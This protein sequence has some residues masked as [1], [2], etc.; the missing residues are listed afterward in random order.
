[1]VR[2]VILRAL[3]NSER[4]T[5]TFRFGEITCVLLEDEEHFFAYHTAFATERVIHP[6]PLTTDVNPTATPEVRK[7]SRHSGLGKLE[8]LHQ[9]AHAE[10]TFCL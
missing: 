10:F 4:Q 1:M 2:R 3:K 8:H 9:I 6:H 7:M 5:V